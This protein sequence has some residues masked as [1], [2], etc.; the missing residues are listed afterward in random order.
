MIGHSGP[1]G[2]QYIWESN[3]SKYERL[4]R[5]LK[6]M[7]FI[8]AQRNLC[9]KDLAEKC[10]VCT[11]TIQRDIDSLIYAGI[12]IFWSKKSGYEIMADFFMP[13][14]NLS[15]EEAFQLA[16]A[17]RAFSVGKEE[18]QQKNIESAISKVIAR[19]SNE[20]R[21]RLDQILDETWSEASELTTATKQDIS[22]LN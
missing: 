18:V 17:A 6:I 9:R 15:L 1:E 2:E 10:E 14:V 12:P 19:L 8:K 4:S 5:L 11:R 13:P 20:T 22:L 21:E 16:A 7:T 3:V